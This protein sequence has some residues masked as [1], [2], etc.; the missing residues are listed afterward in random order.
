MKTVIIFCNT[1][2]NV[3]NFRQK[4]ISELKKKY[5]VIIIAGKDNYST[6]VK[7]F[8]KSFFLNLENRSL[9]PFKNLKEIQHLNKI[10]KNYPDSTM[11]NFTNKSVILGSYAVFFKKIRLVN[12]ITGLGH[13]HLQSNLFVKLIIKFLYL[14]VN[15]RSDLIVVQNK[16]DKILFINQFFTNNK[17]KVIHGSGVDT[18]KF[19]PKKKIKKKIK[20]FLYFGRILKEKGIF[21]YLETANFF[22]KNNTIIFKIVGEFNYKNFSNK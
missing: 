16:Y 3:Y 15:L 7:S 21:N 8:S 14:L 1:S 2:W 4:L 5:K 18:S 11:I 12:V 22:K 19:F 9:N 6:K 13:T 20:T 10:I 17:I